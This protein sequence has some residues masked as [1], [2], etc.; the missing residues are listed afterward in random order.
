MIITNILKGI[1]KRLFAPSQKP[2]F[3]PIPWLSVRILKNESDQS[4]KQRKF[5]HFILNYIRPYEVVK[6]YKEIFNDEIYRFETIYENAPASNLN[7]ISAPIIIDCGANIG[8]SSIYFKTI[9]PH[10]E[11]HAFEPDERIF[12]VLEKNMLDNHYQNVHLHQ[13]AVWTENTQLSFVNKGS[14]ASAI[15]TTGN[16]SHKVNA[17]KLADYI[18][19]FESVDFL[20]MD[21]EGAEFE[22]VQDCTSVLNKV[23]HFFLEYHGLASDTHKLNTLLNM[24]EKAGFKVYIKMAADHLQSPFF[25]KATGELYDVQLNIFC[26][27]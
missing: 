15:D 13:A 19:Q 14:E 9:Y 23:K 25:Q 24:V 7:N 18:N 20:K 4:I 5:S 10:C 8:L 21:I 12:T 27:R 11:L 16:S 22:V 1:R 6:T 3:A 2:R 26:Y 17:I